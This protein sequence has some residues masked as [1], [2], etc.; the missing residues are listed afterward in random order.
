MD[1]VSLVEVDGLVESG[2]DVVD[3]FVGQKRGEGESGMIIDGDMET[4]DAGAPGCARCDHRW[5]GR[6]GARSGPAS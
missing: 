6:Q 4:F 1:A 5:H 3:L 2:E